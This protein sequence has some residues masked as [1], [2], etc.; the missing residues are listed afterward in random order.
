MSASEATKYGIEP[1]AISDYFRVDNP[2]HTHKRSSRPVWRQKISV[3]LG[4]GAGL[5]LATEVGVVAPWSPPTAESLAAGLQPGEVAAI[6][7]AIAGGLDRED[8]QAERWAGK[9]VAQSLGLNV[10]SK[11]D[12]AKAKATLAG[13]IKGGLLKKETRDDG[14]SRPRKHVVVV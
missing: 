10:E 1:W 14:K 4:N 2:K 3:S 6:K 7:D 12:K 11:A 8:S 5:I 9:A 13:L